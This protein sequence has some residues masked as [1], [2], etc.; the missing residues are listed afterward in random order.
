MVRKREEFPEVGELVIATVT[1]IYQHGCFVELEEYGKKEGYIHITE[2][3]STW[4]KNIRDFVR[5]GQRVVAK[6]IR[7]NKEKGHIDLSLRKVTDSERKRK[8]LEWKRS[9]KA[10][11]LLE[12]FAKKV[13][14]SLDEAYERVGFKLEEKYGEI[15]E[16]LLKVAMRGEEALRGLR[17]KKEWREALVK[18]CQENLRKEIQ[19]EI[20]G[21]VEL[22]SYAPNGVEIIKEALLKAMEDKF[23]S[24]TVDIYTVGPPRYKIVVKAPNYK[25]AEETLRRVGERAVAI[26]KEKGGEGNFLG[27]IKE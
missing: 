15:Y 9:I 20:S 24:A 22:R 23:E 1:R 13:G 26:V 16:G 10:E 17:L 3:A 25:I 4:I 12:L 11:K 27:K 8:L 5:E 21:L 19:V 14:I 7:V 6:V 2:I 18:I